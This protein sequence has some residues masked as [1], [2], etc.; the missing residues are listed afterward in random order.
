M[1]RISAI[2]AHNALQ[3]APEPVIRLT[4]CVPRR[5]ETC[6]HGDN[7][8]RH[9]PLL[10]SI[11]AFFVYPPSSQSFRDMRQKK[12]LF[13]PASLVPLL[14]GSPNDKLLGANLSETGKPVIRFSND[15]F[16]SYDPDLL[17]FFKLAERWWAEHSEYWLNLPGVS[18]QFDNGPL[19]QIEKQVKVSAASAADSTKPKWW[20]PAITLG[21]VESKM[22]N[23]LRMESTAEFKAATLA[24]AR[25]LA[26]EGFRTKADELVKELYG[27]MYW[28]V[29]FLLVLFLESS[30]CLFRRPARQ[31][32]RSP[33]TTICGLDRR[34]LVREIIM[35]FGASLL[36]RAPDNYRY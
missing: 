3:V 14:A 29:S 27:P 18:H 26:D 25:R 15:A 30:W 16:Y 9:A 28:C 6:P 8:F 1:P 11:L 31:G 13:P 17:T 2:L 23:A 22:M 33:S 35:I 24:Y 36:C 7:F 12:A 5:C 20:A 19:T 32:D 21:H 10:V 34:E 4:S